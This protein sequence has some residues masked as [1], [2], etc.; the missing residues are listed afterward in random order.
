MEDFQM[1]S[2]TRTVGDQLQFGDTGNPTSTLRGAKK[3]L[4]ATFT[5]SKIEST[6][7]KHAVYEN[8]NRNKNALFAI[9]MPDSNRQLETI[10]NGGNP[11]KNMQMTFSNRPKKTEVAGGSTTASQR[12]PAGRQRYIRSQP[13]I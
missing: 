4:I 2:G 10:R 9:D 11:F 6:Y 7:S 8:S 1:T 13:S 12:Q 3:R 5:N